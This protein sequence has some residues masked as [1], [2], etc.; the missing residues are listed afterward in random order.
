M[1]KKGKVVPK[2]KTEPQKRARSAMRGRESDNLGG[3][4]VQTRVIEEFF[5]GGKN[6]S[7]MAF[8]LYE[9]V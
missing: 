6:F 8:V 1:G 4:A 7:L 5:A 9:K 2:T 3:K